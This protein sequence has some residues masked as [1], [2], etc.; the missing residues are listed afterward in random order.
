VQKGL[1]RALERIGK[2]L[3]RN[4]AL[5]VVGGAVVIGLGV[6]LFGGSP[7][8]NPENLMLTIDVAGTQSN[9]YVPTL[10]AYL[11]LTPRDAALTAAAPTISLA[12]RQEIKQFAASAWASSAEGDLALAAAQAAAP[13]N[14]EGCAQSN[15]AY[16]P[17]NGVDS[18]TLTLF[19]PQL[20][21]PTELAIFESYNPGYVTRVEMTDLLGE[22][23]VIYEGLPQPR[24]D[25]SSP[26]RI[27]IPDAGFQSNI[28]TIYLDRTGAGV[29]W[30][31][32]D[33][34]ELT[35]IKYN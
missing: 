12:G 5:L 28:V 30:T 24:I 13:P 7:N 32:I 3:R 34:V 17:S 33:A 10:A 31:Q 26:L 15:T 11:T 1:G 9:Q 35:G 20:V 8:S 29:L 19:F 14:T 25:C 21:T 18:A 4:I 27:A 22:T 23:H 16:S 6:L 2:A